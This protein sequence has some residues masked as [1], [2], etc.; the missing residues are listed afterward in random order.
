MDTQK[1]D[2]RSKMEEYFGPTAV[3]IYLWV[4]TV[5]LVGLSLS[6]IVRWVTR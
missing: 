2:L 4:L 6:W 1:P 3:S 5:S